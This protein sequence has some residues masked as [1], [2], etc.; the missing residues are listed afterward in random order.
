MTYP[1]DY[2]FKSKEMVRYWTGNVNGCRQC[3]TSCPDRR[4]S[5]G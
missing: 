3:V 2:F 4:G 1:N 5:T